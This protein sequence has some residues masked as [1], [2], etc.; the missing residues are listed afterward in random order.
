[1]HL[2]SRS[3]WFLCMQ[4]SKNTNVHK[5]I[6]LCLRGNYQEHLSYIHVEIDLFL[7]CADGN[8]FSWGLRNIIYQSEPIS[9]W[10]SFVHNDCKELLMLRL[11]QQAIDLCMFLKRFV[12]L[13][14]RLA[15]PLLNPLLLN[16]VMVAMWKLNDLMSV[17]YGNLAFRCSIA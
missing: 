10:H 1:M 6:S 11:K 17:A 4:P 7:A 2:I 8:H 16:M 3:G 9:I 15:S 12:F 5:L 14:D 13:S